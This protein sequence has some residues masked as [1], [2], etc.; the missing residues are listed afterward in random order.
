MEQEVRKE[1]MKKERLSE[2]GEDVGR[3]YLEAEIHETRGW[4]S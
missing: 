4:K 1:T 2:E 3:M